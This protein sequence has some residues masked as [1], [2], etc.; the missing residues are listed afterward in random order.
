MLC[1]FG[2]YKGICVICH[3]WQHTG[4]VH[5]S[6]QADGKDTFEDIPV[7]RVCR[8]AYN[9]SSVHLVVRVL[10][11]DALVL[12]HVCIAFKMCCQHI[13]HVLWGYCS[14]CRSTMKNAIR[15]HTVHACAMIA[16][17]LSYGC[18]VVLL[19]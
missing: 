14:V 2:E 7:F 10:F 18:I 9:D 17:S 3:S 19:L 15:C 13:V 12:P 1:L 6:L 8:P 11:L 16:S 4:V 5:M